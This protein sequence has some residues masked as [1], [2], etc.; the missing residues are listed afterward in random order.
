MAS[1]A[2]CFIL[3]FRAIARAS[4]LDW[5]DLDCEAEGK[6]EKDVKL[7]RFTAFHLRATL[8]IPEGER[9][10]KARLARKSR[11]QLPDHE[12]HECEDPAG[13]EDRGRE[14]PAG[15]LSVETGPWRAERR[16][17]DCP[18]RGLGDTMG[19]LWRPSLNALIRQ[20]SGEFPS[21]SYPG[22]E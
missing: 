8:R 11:G 20:G 6:L 14:R 21:P 13:Y 1:V 7:T 9:V 12:F 16:R 18:G 17:R 19:G 22:L 15:G 5:I 4:K 2:D 3:T 10:E